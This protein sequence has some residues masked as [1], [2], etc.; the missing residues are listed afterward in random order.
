MDRSNLRNTPDFRSGDDALE[1]EELQRLAPTLF[2]IPAEEPFKVPAHFFDRLSH[3][4]QA[5]VVEQEK[6]PSAFTW[7]WRLAIATPVLLVLLGAW[8]FLR[9]SGTVENVAV[10]EETS[11]TIEDLDDVDEVDLFAALASDEAV[12]MNTLGVDLTD[13]EL[14]DYL[15]QEH[16]DLN[17]L[18]SEL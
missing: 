2:G 3:E 15:E 16:T 1:R 13:D 12:T 4:V 7:L 9:D 17:E 6:K 18:I 5:M 8:W 11:P 10:V 14:L